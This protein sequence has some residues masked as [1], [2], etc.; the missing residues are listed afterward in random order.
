MTTQEMLIET[1]IEQYDLTPEDIVTAS[2]VAYN[3]LHDDSFL[4]LKDLDEWKEKSRKY[5][6]MLKA[7]YEINDP[8]ALLDACDFMTTTCFFANERQKLAD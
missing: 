5:F 8:K 4:E 1:A 7:R 3:L 2:Y 6:D